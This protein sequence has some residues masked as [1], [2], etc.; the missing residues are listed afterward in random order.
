MSVQLAN[1]KKTG[2]LRKHRKEDELE[3]IT[4]QQ[5]IEKDVITPEDVIK[6]N[7]IT[8][9]KLIKIKKLKFLLKFPSKVIYAHR[10][11]IHLI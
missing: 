6:L 2:L 4:E 7:K 9:C 1:S 3:T 11:R 8:N 5:L 10:K